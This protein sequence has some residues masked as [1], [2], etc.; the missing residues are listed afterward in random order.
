MIQAK[1]IQEFLQR[2]TPLTR[3]N[4]LPELERLETCDSDMPGC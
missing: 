3:S 4:L 1:R 2:L